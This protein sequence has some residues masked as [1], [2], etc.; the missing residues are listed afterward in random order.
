MPYFSDSESFLVL[1]IILPLKNNLTSFS[2]GDDLT[3]TPCGHVFHLHCVI[4]WFE[5]KKNCP[6]C[7][8]AANER[9]LRK[10]YLSEV[11]GEQVSSDHLQNQLESVQLQLRCLKGEQ[12]KMVEKN[13]QLVEQN[14]LLKDEIKVRYCITN[15]F[16]LNF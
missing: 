13:Q 6:Q 1:I 5:N 7:R 16:I 4:Q 11:D 2:A 15:V 3:S 10:I 12:Q 9:T 8:H 14:K